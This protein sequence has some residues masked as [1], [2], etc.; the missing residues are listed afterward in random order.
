MAK[1]INELIWL[2]LVYRGTGP[3]YW[4][5]GPQH[6]GVQDKAEALQ[7]GEVGADGGVIFDLRV[8]VKPE[9]AGAPVFVGPFAQGPAGGRFLYLSWRNRTGEYAQRFKLPLG[10]I[11]WADIQAAREAERPLM[12]E[13]IDLQPRATSTG[14]NIGGTRTIEWS[15]PAL[16]PNLRS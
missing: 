7:H 8:E 12:G 2:R 1:A 4:S 11:G 16:E 10:S 5:G 9:S 6:F 3:V 13:V 15:L 14:A